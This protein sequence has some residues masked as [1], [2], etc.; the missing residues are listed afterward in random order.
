MAT[1]NR[2]RGNPHPNTANLNRSGRKKGSGREVTTQQE[3]LFCILLKV[4]KSAKIAAARAGYSETSAY[5]LLRQPRIR[6]RLAQTDE[7]SF[8][9]SWEYLAQEYALE[10]SLCDETAARIMSVE[11]P[12]KIRGFSDQVNMVI[13]G[14]KR[15]KLI[16]PP[17]IINNNSA[18]AIA[19]GGTMAEIYKSKWLRDKEA[20]MAADLERER[21]RIRFQA[22]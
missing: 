14:W 20:E 19:A 4:G 17:K 16:D 8:G 12:H 10:V 13:G 1:S 5:Y 6:Q 3:D 7:K 9:E 18:G 15:L 21:A 22:T 11:K 2:K